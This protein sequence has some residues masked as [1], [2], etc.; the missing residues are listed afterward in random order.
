MRQ[1][2]HGSLHLVDVGIGV[3]AAATSQGECLAR[4]IKRL[5]QE[6]VDIKSLR[7]SAPLAPGCET[8]DI[9]CGLL[10]LSES[11]I[12]R[13]KKKHTLTARSLSES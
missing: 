12:G 5:F 11:K 6:Q 13:V 1:D 8:E 2:H 10:D 3:F 9:L 7:T 4:I